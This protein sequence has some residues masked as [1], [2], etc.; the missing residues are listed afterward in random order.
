VAANV[1]YPTDAGLLARAVATLARTVQRVHAAGGARR[2]HARDR[3][4]AA[5]RRAHQL[6][7]SLRARTGQ[8]KQLVAERTTEPAALAEQAT[9][10]PPRSPATP[11]AHWPAPAGRPPGG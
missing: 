5:R 1:G 11:A 7:R 6:A 3:R 2:T 8:A 4:R 10:T 9:P